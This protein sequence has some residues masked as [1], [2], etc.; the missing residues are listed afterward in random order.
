MNYITGGDTRH[1]WKSMLGQ[2]HDLHAII[3]IIMYVLHRYKGYRAQKEGG[4]G[5]CLCVSMQREV[6]VASHCICILSVS[7]STR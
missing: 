7:S 2:A 5:A 6:G 4:G 1:M 3:I